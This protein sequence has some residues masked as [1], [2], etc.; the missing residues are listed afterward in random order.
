MIKINKNIIFLGAPGA[1]KGTISSML[2]KSSNLNH[3]STGNIF[4]SEIANKT[5]LGLQVQQ[6]VNSGKYVPDDITNKIV[7]NNLIALTKENKFFILDG[8]PRTIDQAIFLSKLDLNE[9]YIINLLIDE[10]VIIKRL[11]F[12]V[13]CPECK[14]TFSQLELKEKTCPNDG[15]VL[16]KRKDDEKEAIIKRLEVYKNQTYELIDFYKNQDNYFEINS[17]QKPENILEKLKKII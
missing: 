5:E 15:N 8:Y 10:D 7:K 17:N 16:L 6:L 2:E 13:F 3:I 4:R 9:F 14:E 12:R 1:G 11:S